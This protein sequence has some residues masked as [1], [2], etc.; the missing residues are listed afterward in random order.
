MG[1][2]KMK[3]KALLLICATICTVIVLALT[4]SAP[5]HVA[6]GPAPGSDTFDLA[7]GPAPGSD[8]F[9]LASGPAPGSDTFDIFLASGPA[10]GS[11]TF[12]A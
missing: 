1:E 10:P 8:T 2:L 4:L 6:S 5:R 11:D 9:E 7:S 3:V 12:E